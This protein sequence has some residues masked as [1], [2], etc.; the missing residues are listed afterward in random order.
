[1]SFVDKSNT[2]KV[3]FIETLNLK[4]YFHYWAERNSQEWIK[5]K[6][7]IG[8]KKMRSLNCDKHKAELKAMM[9]VFDPIRTKV[10]THP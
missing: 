7:R 3:H 2:Y 4:N 10:I 8:W 6:V 5:V 1:M 9:A